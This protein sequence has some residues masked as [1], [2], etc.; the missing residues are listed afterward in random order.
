M[1]NGE[2]S[3][4]TKQFALR[5]LRVVASLPRT[6]EGDTL[7]RQLLNAGTSVGANYREARR[8]RSRAEF[9]AKIGVCPQEADESQYWLE[10]LVE[11]GMIRKPLLS[12]LLAETN[13]LIA[14]FASS[15]KTS[16]RPSPIERT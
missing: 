10:L 15:L 9:A 6:R 7:G 4:R 5:I 2:L 16:R 3:E 14:I 1:D 8:A 13:E 11:S 12:P